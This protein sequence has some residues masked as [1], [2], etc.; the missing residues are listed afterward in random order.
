MGD[1]PSHPNFRVKLVAPALVFSM[2]C[3]QKLERYALA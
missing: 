2:M 1:L 3:G